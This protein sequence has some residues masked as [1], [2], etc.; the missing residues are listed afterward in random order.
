MGIMEHDLDELRPVDSRDPIVP[1]TL[2]SF[3]ARARRNLD[4]D[5]TIG[6]VLSVVKEFDEGFGDEPIST[7]VVLWSVDPPDWVASRRLTESRTRKQIA[8][9][10]RHASQSLVFQ[11]ASKH[12]AIESSIH[13]TIAQVM[14][15]FVRQGLI[16]EYHHACNT[17]QMTLEIM[18]DVR[19][20]LYQFQ[21]SFTQLRMA[22]QV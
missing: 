13:S 12:S 15:M 2:V 22:F 16:T 1:G 20:K 21:H 18:V 17:N 11:Q 4:V 3:V 10:V 9:A 19:Y 8:D 6:T 7:V 14:T 5:G